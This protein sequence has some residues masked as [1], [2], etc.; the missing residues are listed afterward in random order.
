[1]PS[2]ALTTF[3]GNGASIWYVV[4][5]LVVVPDPWMENRKRSV[6]FHLRFSTTSLPSYGEETTFEVTWLTKLMLPLCCFNGFHV[7]SHMVIFSMRSCVL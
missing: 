1:M 3:D 5:L 6:C 4:P 2:E 7:R